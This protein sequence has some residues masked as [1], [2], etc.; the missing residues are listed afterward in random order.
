MPVCNLSVNDEAPASILL[1]QLRTEAGDSMV[2]CQD[3]KIDLPGHMKLTNK[4]IVSCLFNPYNR[5]YL[6]CEERK[7]LVL[8]GVFTRWSLSSHLTLSKKANKY[9][10]QNVEQ[11]VCKNQEEVTYFTQIGQ[12]VYQIQHSLI[13]TLGGS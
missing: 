2:L 4:H 1:A 5:L 8:Q 9:I 12:I 6:M 3:N 7:S 11:W 10:S 13:L